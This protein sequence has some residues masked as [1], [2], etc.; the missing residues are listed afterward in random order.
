MKIDKED[1]AVQHLEKAIEMAPRYADAYNNLAIIRAK[2]GQYKDAYN[3]LIRSLTYDRNSPQ[4]HNNLGF[5]LLKTER[6]D[7]A[8]AEF[9]KALAL[10]DGDVNFLQNLGIAYKYKG[11]LFRAVGCFRSILRQEPR[12]LLARLHLAETHSRMGKK[13]V[14][15][16]VVLHTLDLMPPKMVHSRLKS[17]FQ[18]DSFQELPEARIIMPLFK[19]AYLERSDLLHKMGRDLWEGQ[20]SDN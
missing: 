1:E 10:K 16:K 5:V 9:N 4:A 17:F 15:E 6:I 11:N 8:I 12:A 18:E 20:K 13:D 2:R 3:L 7:A 19:N 14:A